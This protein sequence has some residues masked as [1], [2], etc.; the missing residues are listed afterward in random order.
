MAMLLGAVVTIE[1]LIIGAMLLKIDF[2]SADSVAVIL[3]AAVLYCGV[4]ASL[5]DK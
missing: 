5:T 2:R 3:G 1:L 4:V